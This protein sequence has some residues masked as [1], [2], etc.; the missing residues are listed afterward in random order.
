MQRS[1][2][3]QTLE[4]MPECIHNLVQCYLDE[5]YCLEGSQCPGLALEDENFQNGIVFCLLSCLYLGFII[6]QLGL[7][8]LCLVLIVKTCLKVLNLL[9]TWLTNYYKK[10]EETELNEVD[11]DH[12]DLDEYPDVDEYEDHQDL[13]SA[14]RVAEAS[15]DTIK[16]SLRTNS[17]HRRYPSRMT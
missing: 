14:I 2:L 8:M 10:N 11:E 5:G 4:Q 6:L 9:I 16:D 15:L 1:A 3:D 12:D 17:R 13:A 7:L